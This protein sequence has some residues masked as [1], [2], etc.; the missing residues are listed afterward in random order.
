MGSTEAAP[1]SLEAGLKDGWYT[2][3]SSLWPGCGMSLQIEEVLFRGRSDFQVGLAAYLKRQHA[4][5]MRRGPPAAAMHARRC[6][7]RRLPAPTR[8]PCIGPPRRRTWPW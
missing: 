7:G 5:A 4:R 1:G 8:L 2:E 3:I 6:F